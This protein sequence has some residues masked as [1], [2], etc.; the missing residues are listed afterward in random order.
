VWRREAKIYACEPGK[1]E[2][3]IGQGKSCTMET[4]NGKNVYAWVENGDVVVL[5]PGGKK[6]VVGKG[7]MPVLKAVNNEQV[8]CVWEDEK[9]VHK[10]IL[11][12]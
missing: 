9:Q 1:A 11:E 8:L 2:T 3:E 4:V 12:L 10:T 7:L 5:K 6:Q